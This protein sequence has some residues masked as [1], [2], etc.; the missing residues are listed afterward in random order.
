MRSAGTMST[1]VPLSTLAGGA[2]CELD[3]VHLDSFLHRFPTGITLSLPLRCSSRRA[4]TCRHGTAAAGLS[5]RRL[6]LPC[7]L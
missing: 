5:A 1:C 4:T 2:R 6:A 3:F 7:L